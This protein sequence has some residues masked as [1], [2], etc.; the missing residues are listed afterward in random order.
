MAG[1]DTTKQWWIG[2]KV[3]ET[4]RDLYWA[5]GRRG[6]AWSNWLKGE[7]NNF[8]EGDPCVRMVYKKS[9]WQWRDNLCSVN[10]SFI[11]RDKYGEIEI[12]GGGEYTSLKTYFEIK[13]MNFSKFIIRLLENNLKVHCYVL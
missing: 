8:E 6:L 9:V 2:L 4:S 3:D 13:D 10:Y 12:S 11:C 5:D 7:P 1:V